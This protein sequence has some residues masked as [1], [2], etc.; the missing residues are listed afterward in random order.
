MSGL[1]AFNAARQRG[2]GLI[3][4][5]I[6]LLLLGIGT[7][8]LGSL[9]IAAKRMGHE[10]AQRAEAAALAMDLLERIR[11]NR[12]ELAAYHATDLG[13]AGGV[14]RAVPAVDCGAERCS[15]AQMNGWDLWQWE[16]AL[17]G[18][19]T[20]GGRGGLVRPTACVTVSG[21][22]VT[23]AIAWQGFRLLSSPEPAGSCGAGNYGHDEADR[24][25]LQMRSWIGEE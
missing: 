5:S 19:A 23:V 1:K 10:A 7:L 12:S 2:A 20:G 6:S 16:Q 24:Q 3:E 8:G 14:Q 4:V 25:Q 9:Q 18:M 17:D 22:Q 11:G 21:R 15:P 13:E